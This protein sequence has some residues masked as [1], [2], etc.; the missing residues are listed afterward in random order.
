[1]PFGLC[2]FRKRA[3]MNTIRII[4]DSTCDLDASLKEGLDL[5]ILPLT[6]TIADKNYL[7]GEEI[8]VSDVYSYM[9]KGIQ[10]KTAQ[11]PYDRIYKLF[12]ECFEKGQDFIYIAFSSVMSGCYSLANMIIK[13]LSVDYPECKYAVIDSKGGSGATGLIVL[14]ALRM[15]RSCLPFETVKS[16]IQF[17]TEHV[18]HV[19]SVDDIDW[20]AKGGR[21][22]KV[23]GYVGSKLGIRPILDVD[24]GYMIF[25]KLTRGHKRVLRAVADEIISR[26]GAFQ[27]QLIAI[28]HADDIFSAKELEKYILEAL[29]KCKTTICHIGAVLGVHIGLNGIGAFCFNRKSPHYQFL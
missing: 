1:M 15:V 27:S 19:F 21:I 8:S 3:S 26:A 14:Q 12:K 29:P 7:D 22:S 24:N 2:T 18:E 4:A 13:E 10:P 20:L 28:S 9:R 23:A 17:L 6:I 5:A 11:I 16:E 25:R